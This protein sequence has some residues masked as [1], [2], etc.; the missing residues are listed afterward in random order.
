V[1]IVG[2]AGHIDHGKTS[3]VRALT[4]VDTDRLKE[5]KARGISIDLGFAYLPTPDGTV[6]GFV[7]VPGHEKF[8][9][10]MLAGATGIDFVLL[11]VAA[12]DGIMP[13]T[14]EHLAIVEL[15]GMDCGIVAMTMADL[16]DNARRDQV[17]G[18]IRQMLETTALTGCEIVPVST[19]TGEGVERLRTVL[20]ESG[21]RHAKRSVRNRF[22]MSIDRSFT[23]Q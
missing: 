23:L 17:T 8:I 14:R 10:N 4:G 19:V 3:L 5:E 6:L 15:L 12:D 22:R 18:E 11:V 20:L 9:H 21:R 7:D 2:T 16:A 1:M 13:Q